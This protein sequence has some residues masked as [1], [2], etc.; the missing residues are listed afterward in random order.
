MFVGNV[1]EAF[2]LIAD[3]VFTGE[4]VFAGGKVLA[5]VFAEGA[6]EVLGGSAKHFFLSL[7]DSGTT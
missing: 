4:V 7:L 1:P 3:S 6:T 5:L 2:V